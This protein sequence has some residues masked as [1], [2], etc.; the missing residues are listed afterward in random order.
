[1][2]EEVTF[3][4]RGSW[5]DKIDGLPLE[6]KDKILADIVRY[7]TERKME[8]KDDPFVQSFVNM[9]KDNINYS[10][11]LYEKKS[12][13]GRPEKVTDDMIIE[14]IKMGK[15]STQMAKEFGCD[16]STIT[17]RP[18]WKNRKEILSQNNKEFSF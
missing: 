7:G 5:L 16:S 4:V 9:V 15:T 13:G 18:V 10:K 14:G 12:K 11:D 2:A 6:Y 3:I 8:Y 17:K 1:M